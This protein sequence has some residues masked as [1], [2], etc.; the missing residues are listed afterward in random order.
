MSTVLRIFMEKIL[1]TLKEH[2]KLVNLTQKQVASLCCI[3]ERQY[4]RY[5]TGE[6]EPGVYTALKIAEVLKTTVEELY[7][8]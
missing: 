5:E 4:I 7:P 2:R 1:S 3:S 6:Q 8:D